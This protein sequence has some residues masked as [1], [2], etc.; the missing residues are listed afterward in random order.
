LENT[1]LSA[2]DNS[3]NKN[4]LRFVV[5]WQHSSEETLNSII[6]DK[7]IEIIDVDYR[8]SKGVCW[9]RS[10]IQSKYDGEDYF[11]QIDGHHRFAKDWDLRL[12]NM[13]EGLKADGIAKPIL[14]T[15]LPSYDPSNDPQGRN[16]NVWL[17][18]ID[19]FE[20]SVVN[21]F[22]NPIV[23]NIIVCY[24]YYEPKAYVCL[25]SPFVNLSPLSVIS[26]DLFNSCFKS[27]LVSC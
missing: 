25:A 26:V 8:D 2:I 17:L 27:I 21:F 6:Y 16:N 23:V 5:C 18:G 7:K 3:F 10:L 19:R 12:I 13:L 11:L 24:K 9:A 15:Y 4:S 1:I 20:P 22:N 14:T